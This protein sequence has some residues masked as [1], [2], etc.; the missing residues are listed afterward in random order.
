MAVWQPLGFIPNGDWR[1]VLL[2]EPQEI[3]AGIAPYARYMQ[4][5]LETFRVGIGPPF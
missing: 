1:A 4:S 2:L 3:E 5:F